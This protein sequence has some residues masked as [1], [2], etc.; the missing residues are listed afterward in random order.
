MTHSMVTRRDVLAGAAGLATALL[1]RR[2]SALPDRHAIAVVGR[3]PMGAAAAR[4]LAAHV[5]NVVVVGPEEPSAEAAHAGAFASHYDEGRQL[6]LATDSR[7]LAQLA[8]RSLGGF[9]EAEQESGIAFLRE[10]ANL[11]VRDAGYD[12][13]HP[14]DW[15]DA[16]AVA[17][18]LGAETIELDQAGLAERFPQLRFDSRARALLEPRGGILNPRA[19]VRAQ[20]R[21][22]ELRGATVVN[23][24]VVRLV[25][26]RDGVELALRSGRRL[27]ADRVLVATGAFTNAARLLERRLALHLYG[28]TVVLVHVPGEPR[29]DFPTFTVRFGADEKGA[30]C[31]AMPPLRYPDGRFYIKAATASSLHSRIDSDEAIGAWFRGRGVEEDPAIVSRLLRRLLPGFTLGDAHAVPCMVSYTPSG[32]PYIDRIDERIGVAVGGNAWGVMTSDEIGRLAAD[33]MRGAPW[34]GPLAADL[35]RVRFA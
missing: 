4:H 7:V 32:A 10:H 11:R 17:R 13:E 30:V 33:M 14:F 3:G 8:S 2:A 29:P 6:E 15:G 16:V 24:E 25:R 27:R 34:T 20:L 18:E 12:A 1:G 35:F 31:F 28:V 22:A 26:Q 21:A 19:M 9:R 5:E 23:D